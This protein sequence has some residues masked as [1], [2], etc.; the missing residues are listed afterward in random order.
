MGLVLVESRHLGYNASGQRSFGTDCEMVSAQLGAAL[1]SRTEDVGH[2]RWEN[3]S[4]HL[5]NVAGCSTFSNLALDNR[6]GFTMAGVQLRNAECW[7]IQEL[8]ISW[9][10]G[11]SMLLA[12]P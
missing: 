9:F 5:A 11:K 10:R 12:T 4:N 6:K 2:N 7:R 3:W 8:T 1:P